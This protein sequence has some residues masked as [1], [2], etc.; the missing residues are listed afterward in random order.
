MDTAA[1]HRRRTIAPLA[2]IVVLALFAGG[3]SDSSDDSKSSSS[4][5]STTASGT[6]DPSTPPSCPP[7]SEVDETLNAGL[8]SPTD[9]INGSIRTCTYKT[10]AG[11]DD[12]V[13][14][15]ETGVTAA[16]FQA[17]EQS[18]GPSGETATPIA[19]LG[20]V[21]Y[22]TKRAEPGSEVTTLAVLSGTTEV[23]VQAPV[24]LAQLEALTRKLLDEI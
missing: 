9:Q 23:S 20:D 6:G 5:N 1:A 10:T 4:S 21:A 15:F 12:V 2:A 11:G 24:E 18:P 14:R 13:I 8:D 22:S 17:A 3:C 16:D 19:G 7:A